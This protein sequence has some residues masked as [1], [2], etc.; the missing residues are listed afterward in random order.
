MLRSAVCAVDSAVRIVIE[1]K[2][3][4][5]KVQNDQNRGNRDISIQSKASTFHTV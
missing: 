1:L 4:S 3:L 5:K 2:G